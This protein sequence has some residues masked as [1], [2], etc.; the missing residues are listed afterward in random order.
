[1]FSY[2]TAFNTLVLKIDKGIDYVTG[3]K[4]KGLFESNLLPVLPN[5]KYFGCKI[6]IQLESFFSGRTKQLSNQNGKCLHRL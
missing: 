6:G 3:W 4:S 5:I 1:M 2:Q